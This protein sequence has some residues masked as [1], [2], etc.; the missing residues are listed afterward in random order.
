MR[1]SAKW[2]RSDICYGLLKICEKSISNVFSGGSFVVLFRRREHSKQ[3]T[4]IQALSSLER[5]LESFSEMLTTSYCVK[6]R[7]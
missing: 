6:F 7:E 3:R 2:H 4:V 5:F 1:Q